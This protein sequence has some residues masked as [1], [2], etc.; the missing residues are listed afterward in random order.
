MNQMTN[1]TEGTY[2]DQRDLLIAQGERILNQK[3]EMGTD[4]L[5]ALASALI[6]IY[7]DPSNSDLRRKKAAKIVGDLADQYDLV[8]EL[9]ID[10]A[11]QYAIAQHVDDASPYHP[12]SFGVLAHLESSRTRAIVFLESIVRNDWGIPRWEALRVLGNF[13]A[14]S[15]E[16][17]IKK[18]MRGE[19]PP[20]CYGLTEDLRHIR[21][22]KGQDYIDQHG[23]N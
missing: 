18:V 11:Q 12:N 15:A 10:N 9:V 14:P 16:K 20:K 2:E 3:S 1:E 23:T 22:M 21:D 6:A 13:D 17:I 8:L 4:D 7:N 19:Y 5:R